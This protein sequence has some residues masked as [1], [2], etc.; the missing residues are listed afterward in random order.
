MKPLLTVILGL[1]SAGLLTAATAPARKFV[2]HPATDSFYIANVTSVQDVA[3]I[4]ESLKEVQSF[5]KIEAL[6]PTSGYAEISF[7]AHA[8]SYAEVAQAIMNARSSTGRPFAVSLKIRIKD[9][10]V[11]GN[12]PKF[13]AVF[14]ASKATV[15]VETVDA[16]RGDFIIHFLPFAR[17]PAK[18]SPQGWNWGNF[19]H[20]I[21]DAPP[22]GLGL[23]IIRLHEGVT[24]PAS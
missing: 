19:Y 8:N 1:L 24:P 11:P 14:A 15:S 9:Y 4:S 5:S 20:P 6:S 17:D 7:D 3:R 18:P 21:Q 2:P 22:K 23:T 10:A 12:A 16:K 13:D